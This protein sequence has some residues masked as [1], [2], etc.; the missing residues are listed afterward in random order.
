MKSINKDA[1][2]LPATIISVSLL[3]LSISTLF[4]PRA[5]A[6]ADYEPVT[7]GQIM[8]VPVRLGQ[9]GFGLAMIDSYNQTMWV[10]EFNN[11]GS[12]HNRLRLLAARS[13]KYD[14]LLQQ[15]NNSE[16]TPGSVKQLLEGFG[17]PLPPE[18]NAVEETTTE[19][20]N[21]D[22]EAPAISR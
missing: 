13:Y 22:K 10:Y 15:Y 20:E 14:R 1:W 19:I 21:S 17:Q 5:T 4:A 8:A 12:A 7:D 6:T 2:L 18:P 3:I 9:S 11:R 16:P